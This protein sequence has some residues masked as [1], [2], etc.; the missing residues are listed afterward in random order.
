MRARLTTPLRQVLKLVTQRECARAVARAAA[1]RP[2]RARL[3]ARS[4]LCP[5][6]RPY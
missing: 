2:K 4:A 5:A 6:Q 1:A 3:P